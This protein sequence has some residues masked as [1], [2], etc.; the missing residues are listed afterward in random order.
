[1][2]ASKNKPVIVPTDWRHKMIIRNKS[3]QLLKKGIIKKQKCQVCF[4]PDTKMTHVNYDEPDHVIW[5]C[6]EHYLQFQRERRKISHQSKGMQFND[7]A[8][9]V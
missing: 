4:S 7:E 8:I 9:N 1:M 5:L 2:Q 6:K 3:R